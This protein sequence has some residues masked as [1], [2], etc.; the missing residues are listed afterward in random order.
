MSTHIGST[1]ASTQN[2]QIK[3]S[4]GT[5]YRG[6]NIGKSVQISLPYCYN[7]DYVLLDKKQAKKLI[8]LLKKCYQDETI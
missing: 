3:I 4:V 8:K 5:F 7:K 6:K 2:E 1:K